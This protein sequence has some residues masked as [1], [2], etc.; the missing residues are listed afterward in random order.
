MGN[1]Q[2]FMIAKADEDKHLVFGWA[3]VCFTINGEQVSDWQNDLIDTDVL[4]N[5]VYQYVLESREAGEMH[6]RGGTGTLVESLILTKEKMAAMGIPPGVVPE[7]W[8]IGFKISDNDVWEKIKIG[9][10]KMFS[11][12]GEAI[13]KAIEKRRNV[14]NF[15]NL[16]G[17][18]EKFNPFDLEY[19]SEEE[20]DANIIFD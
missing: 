12:E 16:I 13:R 1:S 3:S 2:T 14:A 10:Y 15:S 6:Q 7:G 17:T 11:I 19:L 18:I 20:Y 5:A 8:W 9:K 4:E